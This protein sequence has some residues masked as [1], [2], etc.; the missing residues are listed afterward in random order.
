MFSGVSAGAEKWGSYLLVLIA[1]TIAIS[2]FLVL[3]TPRG[4]EGTVMLRFIN[5]SGE[6]S[7]TTLNLRTGTRTPI[8]ELPA[9]SFSDESTLTLDVQGIAALGSDGTRTLLVAS[10]VPPSAR[11]PFVQSADRTRLAWVSPADDSI[12]IFERTER[13]AYVPLT[14]ITSER[15][16]SLA[17]TPDG[18]VLAFARVE[19]EETHIF[20]IELGADRAHLVAQLPGFATLIETP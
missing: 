18:T 4:P 20:A 1:L 19:S 9:P 3:S 10:P 15:A 13:G 2:G 17:F 6:Q 12:Q 8:S 11:T 7:F 14:L 16:N 5:E